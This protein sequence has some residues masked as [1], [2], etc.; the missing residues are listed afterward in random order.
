MFDVFVK[1]GLAFYPRGGVL[2]AQLNKVFRKSI[3]AGPKFITRT[4]GQ[5]RGP[6]AKNRAHNILRQIDMR[7]TLTLPS[8]NK[9]SCVW[10]IGRNCLLLAPTRIVR[11]FH[12][13]V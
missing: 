5:N 8:L 13:Q 4:S 7:P 9:P 11:I 6:G 12:K 10:E 3:N 1:A 2:G